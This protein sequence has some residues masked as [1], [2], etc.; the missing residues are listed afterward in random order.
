MLPQL[1]VTISQHLSKYQKNPRKNAEYINASSAI[2]S[3][4][5][6]AYLRNTISK[7][8]KRNKALHNNEKLFHHT[9]QRCR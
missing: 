2:H 8:R 7:N 6:Q 5:M 1:Q 9:T 3:R 4:T